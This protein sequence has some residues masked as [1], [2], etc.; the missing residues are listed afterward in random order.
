[1]MTLTS[2]ELRRLAL[3]V[4]IAHCVIIPNC[5]GS[6]RTN[7]H[8]AHRSDSTLSLKIMRLLAE[9]EL[10]MGFQGILIQSLKDHRTLVESNADKVFLPA[11]NNKLLTSGAA[12]ELLGPSFVYR[13]RLV[14][15]G[16]LSPQGLLKGDLILVGSG[17][18]LLTP[19]NL[20]EMAQQAQRLGIR[21]VTGD[22]L[23]DDTLFDTQRLGDTWSW[24]DEP[25]YY[26]AQISALNL[27]ENLVD[28]RV[29]PGKVAGG[30]C[31]VTLS[32]TEHYLELINA[33][34]TGPAGSKTTVTFDRRRGLNTLL[35]GGSVPVDCAAKDSPTERITVENPG[36]YTATVLQEEL[37]RAHI[38]TSGRIAAAG[39]ASAKP[40]KPVCEHTS[41]PMT[42]LLRLMNKP[43]DNLVAECLLKT[44]GAMKKGQGTGGS[45]GTAAQAAR[46]FFQQ[47]GFNLTQLHQADGS[48]LSR[49]NFVSPRNMVRLLTY[50]HSR[51]YFQAFYDSLPIAGVDGSLAGR[52]RGTPAANNCHAKTGYVSNVSSLSGYVTTREGEM[53]VFSLLMNNHLAANRKCTAVQDQI[54]SLLANYRG[55][56]TLNGLSR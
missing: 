54:V 1:M 10:Q 49:T 25:Y 9:P 35:I 45:E 28:I 18:P 23:F 8:A 33:A 16:E 42:T 48:G 2:S 21:R 17:D 40:T 12:I 7:L 15:S 56:E 34:V 11:S 46:A 30:Q 27:N 36:L 53:L 29:A 50:L 13:T 22:I 6:R 52:M 32:P 41:A 55:N 24:D 47:I 31:Q 19:E 51:P 44:V 39:P 26:S 43:S 20:K 3:T 37:N 38:Q 4:V 5:E 14:M